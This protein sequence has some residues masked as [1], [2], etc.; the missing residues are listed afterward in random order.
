MSYGAWRSIALSTLGVYAVLAI[1][2]SITSI[3][4]Y[5]VFSW[6][7][8]SMIP[9]SHVASTMEFLEI[10]GKVQ[11]PPL[12]FSDSKPLFD[13]IDKS[14]TDYTPIISELSRAMQEHNSA[15]IPEIRKRLEVI[16]P[17]GPYRYRI[18][19]VTYDPIQY[20]K[21]HTYL[22]SQVLGEFEGSNP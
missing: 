12:A 13:A 4:G 15:K 20:W 5:P 14:P 7:L 6:S 8:F 10:G 19:L 2:M 1:I 21:T 18:L 22:R 11:M 3:E 16:F 9:N 17:P